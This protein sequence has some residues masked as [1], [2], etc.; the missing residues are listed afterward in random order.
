LQVNVTIDC[1]PQEARSFL[2]LPDLSPLH[3]VYLDKMKA[4]ATDGVKSEDLERLYRAWG[5]GL[6]EGV[7]QWQRLFWHATSSGPPTTR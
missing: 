1:T 3:D 6:S 7:E 4:F 5:S 2:G